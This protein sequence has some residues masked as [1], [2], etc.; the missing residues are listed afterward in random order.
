MWQTLHDYETVVHGLHHCCSFSSHSFLSLL[1]SEFFLTTYLWVLLCGPCRM[2]SW[3][4]LAPLAPPGV[5]GS[6]TAWS[7]PSPTGPRLPPRRHAIYGRGSGLSCARVRMT[8][9]LLQR[10]SGLE[11]RKDGQRIAMNANYLRSD[12]LQYTSGH[13]CI[14]VKGT[15]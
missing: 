7:P 6:R 8:P 14:K 5:L 3:G 1:I 11:V 10:A 15:G 2:R 4:T 12:K 13:C 9:S